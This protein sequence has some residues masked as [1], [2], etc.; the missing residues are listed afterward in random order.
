VEEICAGLGMSK[1]TFYRYF[2][3]RNDLATA[4]VYETLGRHA[5]DIVENLASQ[6]PVDEILKTHFD[7]VINK[8]LAGV[9]T[10]VLADVQLFLPEVWDNI[11]QFRAEVIRT[12]S[13]LLHRG[14]REG[15]VRTDIDPAAAGKFIQGVVSK[16]ANPAFLLEQDLTMGQFIFTF[17]SLLLHGVLRKGPGEP[18]YEQKTQA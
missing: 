6:K 9:S 11:V 7:L 16:M 18:P 12:L 4:V 5:P 13:E 14:Q 3:D 17:Q 10:Q 2:S 1:R 15:V 8:V